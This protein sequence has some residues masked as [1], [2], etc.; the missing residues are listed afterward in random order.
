MGGGAG[1]AWNERAWAFL[2]RADMLCELH[3]AAHTTENPL[4]FA[5]LSRGLLLHFGIGTRAINLDP[6]DDS[7]FFA[8]VKP[9]DAALTVSLS[10]P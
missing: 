5:R 10:V 2:F 3:D 4:A 7:S 6:F 1:E 8:A 9:P